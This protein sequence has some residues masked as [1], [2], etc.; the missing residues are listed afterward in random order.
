MILEVVWWVLEDV[1]YV[2]CNFDWENISVILG[3]GGGI[4]DLG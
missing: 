2:N 3:V 4:V 1:G